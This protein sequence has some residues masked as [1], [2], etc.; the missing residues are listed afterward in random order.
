MEEKIIKVLEEE[1]FVDIFSL[2]VSVDDKGC[3]TLK[4]EKTGNPICSWKVKNTKKSFI[5]AALSKG[6]GD[7]IGQRRDELFEKFQETEREVERLIAER[8][9]LLKNLNIS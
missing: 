5:R 6:R 3:C 4:D 8:E 1:F 7:I 9:T 2:S